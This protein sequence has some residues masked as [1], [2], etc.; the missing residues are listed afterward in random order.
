MLRLKA[1]MQKSSK[2]LLF[3]LR[4][5]LGWLYLYAGVTKILNPSWTSE[6]YI[7]SAKTFA[8]LYNVFLNPTLLPIVNFVNEWGLTLL[9]ISLITGICVR[10]S[11]ILGAFLMLL[12]YFVI[13]DFPYVNKN[14]FLVDQH[15]IFI[16]VL[17]L[18]ASMQPKQFGTLKSLFSSLKTFL[19][20]VLFKNP[21]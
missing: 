2:F 20:K 10:L 14:F 17:L 13:L 6:E 5:F 1:I 9:G 16:L 21:L 3:F 15:V 19:V 12:Y 4:V 18:F 7:K 8:S 11:S